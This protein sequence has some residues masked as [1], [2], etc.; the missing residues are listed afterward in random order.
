VAIVVTITVL[1]MMTT[2]DVG[3]SYDVKVPNRMPG[4]CMD[5]VHSTTCGDGQSLLCHE[6]KSSIEQLGNYDPV[7]R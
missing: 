4:R 5:T 2:M 7:T 1:D 6:D 3:L